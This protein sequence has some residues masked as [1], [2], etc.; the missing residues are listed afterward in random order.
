M[1]T[2]LRFAGW[3]VT[4]YPNDHRPAHVHA[5]GKD[6]EAVFELN[7]PN[8]PVALRENYG[9]GRLE[10]GRIR[11]EVER[12]LGELCKEWERIHGVDR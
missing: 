2:I 12:A 1:P 4:I 10:I 5:I 6:F 9:C 3:R 11:R 7:C 8:G